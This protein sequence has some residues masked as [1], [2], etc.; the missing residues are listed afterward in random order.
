MS[1]KL[2][3]AAISIGLCL[4]GGLS[5]GVASAGNLTDGALGAGAGAIVGGP[6]GAV[7]GGVIG[8]TAG[9]TIDC[10]LRGGCRRHHRH[11]RHH[12]HPHDR[13]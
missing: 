11:D 2:K 7:A 8:Y 3:I 4:S 9:P 10:G 6:A 1:Q 5:G 12:R 13:N